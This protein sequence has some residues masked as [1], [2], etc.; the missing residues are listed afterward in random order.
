MIGG[1]IRNAA[2][3]PQPAMPW[4]PV[5]NADG[6]LD[7]GFFA[8]VSQIEIPGV[9]WAWGNRVA[10]VGDKY[11]VAGVLR[12]GGELWYDHGFL[13]RLTNSGTLDTSFGPGA[14]AANLPTLDGEV[15]DL[16]LQ[17]DGK[18]VVSGSFSHVIDGSTAPPARSAI[19]RFAADGRLDATFLPNLTMP[20]GANAMVLAAMARQPNGK[21]LIEKNFFN[22]GSGNSEFQGTQVARLNSNGS[23]DATFT[24]GTPAN[25]GFWYGGGNSI[26]RLPHGKALI[27]GFY[28][29]YNTTPAWSL[30]RILAG[31][32]NAGTAGVAGLL[33][34]D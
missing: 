30:V 32:G 26:L 31:P 21:I 15:F 22:N 7:S 3:I 9:N 27:G 13:C 17:P 11:L 2:G 24:L 5:C 12:Y 16:F 6:S 28:S 23:L 14:P 1:E 8:N 29:T 20:T 18:I 19:A 25:G 4:W 34:A 33:L 10:V